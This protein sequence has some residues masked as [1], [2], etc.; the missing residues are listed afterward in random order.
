MSIE[1]CGVFWLLKKVTLRRI[2]VFCSLWEGNLS[3]ATT[4]NMYADISFEDIQNVVTGL[5]Q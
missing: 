5:Y 4:A 1:N 3:P 2:L